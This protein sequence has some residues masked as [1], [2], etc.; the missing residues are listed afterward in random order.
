MGKITCQCTYCGKEL[1]RFPSKS[2]CYFCDIKCKA[3]YQRLQKPITKEELYDLYIEQRLSANKIA[4]IVH[5]NPKRVWEWLKEYDIPTRPR[6][7]DYGQQFHK[8]ETNYWK[9]K[10]L[11]EETKEKIRQARIRDGHVPYLINGIHWLH[12]TGRK[13]ASWK[14]GI[15]PERQKIYSSEKWKQCVKEVW[16]RDNATC[17]RCGKQYN[18]TDRTQHFHIHHK[19]TFADYPYLRMNPDNLVL[20][21]P[22][23]HHFVH[24]KA[25]VE[26]DFMT[27]PM[28]IP[29]WLYTRTRSE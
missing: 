20:L 14:G 22:E 4:E 12:A 24:S 21:C 11:S 23:C 29:K 27:I 26:H 7:T 6:G 16:K 8:G 13:P 10:H 25:N 17:Q 3:E 2:G 1:Q 19:Y 18:S 9:G 15:T 28:I 5:R